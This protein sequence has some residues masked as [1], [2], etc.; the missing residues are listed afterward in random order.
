MFLIYS[1]IDIASFRDNTPYLFAI[2][3]EGVVES[4]ERATVSLFRS[5]E[6][7]LLK[8]DANE[9]HFLLSTIQEVRYNVNNFKIKSSDCEKILGL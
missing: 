9:C 8:S 1:D 7:N 4:R 6:N 2:N 3:V 5:F